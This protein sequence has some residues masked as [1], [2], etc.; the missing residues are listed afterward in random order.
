MNLAIIIPVS[1]HKKMKLADAI[2]W[3]MT[4]VL[5]SR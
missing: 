2:I 5:N 3:A 4:F 1:P